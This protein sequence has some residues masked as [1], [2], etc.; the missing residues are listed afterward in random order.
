MRMYGLS[1]ARASLG[2]VLAMILLPGVLEA[3]A[4]TRISGL[5]FFENRALERRL[6]M[7]KGMGEQPPLTRDPIDIEDDAYL[8]LQ[9]LRR[10]GFPDPGVKGVLAR[11][12][13]TEMTVFWSLP[14]VPQLRTGEAGMAFTAV[15][16]ICE[17]GLRNYFSSVS[18]DGLSLMTE[19]D[20]EALFIPKSALFTPRADRAYTEQ[21]LEAGISR[22]QGSLRAT[23][24]LEARVVGREVMSD[25]STGATEVHLRIE[26][27]PLFRLGRVELALSAFLSLELSL[28]RNLPE[29]QPLRPRTL[30][31]IRQHVLNQLLRS[32]YPE[33]RID[34][35]QQ[36]R[37]GAGGHEVLVD[38]QLEPVPGPRVTFAGVGFEP[39]GWM[40]SS[41]LLRQ[42]RLMGMEHFNLLAIEEGRRRLLGLGHFSSVE[43]KVREPSP[44]VRRVTYVMHPLPQQRL[45]LRLGYGSY[46]M[47]RAGILWEHRN[48]FGRGHHYAVELR[49][50]FKASQLSWTYTLPQFFDQRNT[51]F[52]RLGYDYREEISYEEE[53]LSLLFGV[54]R[55]L[56]LAGAEAAMEFAFEDLDTERDSERVFASASQARVSSLSFSFLLDRRDSV[57]TPTRGFDISLETKLATSLLGGEAEFGKFEAAASYHYPLPGTASLHFGLRYGY[58]ASET[59]T[60]EFLPF[61]ERFF[62]GG[63]YSI[64]GYQRGEASP[65][66]V[67]GDLLGAESYF[68]INVEVQQP[69]LSSLFLVVFYDFL[70]TALDA[71]PFPEDAF[72]SSLGLG[73]RWKTPVGPVRFEYGHNLDPRPLDPQGT[74]HLSVGFPF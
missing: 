41:V 47:G 28:P 17:P 42:S 3:E 32:G 46:E 15:R 57:L 13:D 30:Q 18:F 1:R 27:G 60:A 45:S 4:E 48:P 62:P 39:E 37:E 63:A 68:L 49:R 16:F 43:L 59:P 24:H 65:L 25:P 58:I 8:I 33:A 38:A 34:F 50:S 51:A 52:T 2:L 70:G 72:L 26:E 56:A 9:L 61:A 10:M 7:L 22:L 6:Q 29:G 35:E 31:E 54:S 64:R 21:A 20:A 74:F 67:E 69:I 19:E 14:F 53:N 73:L 23:G 44:N 11:S 36:R 12:D 55:R 71:E 40:T 66:D 5:G